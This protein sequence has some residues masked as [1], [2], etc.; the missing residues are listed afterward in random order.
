MKLVRLIA[1]VI[2]LIGFVSACT[3]PKPIFEPSMAAL[4]R[5][6]SPQLDADSERNTDTG[7]VVGFSDAY[8]TY[9]WLNIPYA[10]P[11]IGDL[12][13][14]APKP[15]KLWQGSREA[16]TY[17]PL[18]L[19]YWGIISGEQ[20]K[21]GDIL[22]SE[23]CLSLNIWA[24]K[25]ANKSNLKPVMFWI[26]GGG[27]ESG[28]AKVFQAHHLA[29][30][31][32]VIVV[33]INYRLG[34][35]GWLSHT[36]IRE[37]AASPEDASGNFGTLDIIA[38]LKW[39]QRNIHNFG[40][41][42][43]N[44]TIFGE[45]AG[46]RN[47][48]SLLA[49][50]LA[51]GLFHGAI[52]QSGS[53]DTTPLTLAE[54]FADLNNGAPISGL[55]N[56]SNGLFASVLKQEQASASDEQ[57]K[58]QLAKMPAADLMQKLRS[59]GGEELMKQASANLDE[60][61]QM[62][63]ARIIRDGYVIP[64]ESLLTLFKNPVAYNSV[65]LMLGTNRDEQKLFLSRNPEMV[66]YW[67]N[68]LPR[69]K[70][71]ALY[72]RV[73][74]Y[75]SDNWKAGSVDEPAKVITSSQGQPVFA[76][77]FDWDESPKNWL[78]DLPTLIGAAHGL[79]ISFVFGDF[80]GGVPLGPLLNAQNAPGRKALS[81]SIM[82]YWGQFAHTGNPGQGRSGEQE[83]WSQWRDQGNNLMVLETPEGGGVRMAEIRTNVS[84]IKARIPTDEILVT[85][86]QKC[87]A[88]AFLFLHS[89]MATDFW[90]P[91]EYQELGCEDYPALRFRE[92]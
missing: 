50:P 56:S 58:R 82:D 5:D 13:W 12:R 75:I 81:T 2:M 11:P 92:G 54:D 69:I 4:F 15:A 46:G 74:K 53:V 88:F 48:Y 9:G 19:Q 36:A 51:K 40:G 43:N 73:S 25:S 86:E 52:S 72:N 17:G 87:E 79:E 21:A 16:N 38:A 8:Q 29:G 26:H 7:K 10:M 35:M 84:E 89:Y 45:S 65:P 20:G 34:L 18:C 77:R 60:V 57:I 62:R 42:S 80:E 76:Y 64:Q 55:I 39:V 59:I 1:A 70:D 14:R 30:G 83:R 78:A 47:V 90:N 32:D 37:L 66:D 85:Q 3:Q 41:D 91:Q 28:T 33:T 31:Q 67:F 71:V 63:I 49:S 24:P 44:V 27:N 61:E 68:W 23:D 6:G 22:G